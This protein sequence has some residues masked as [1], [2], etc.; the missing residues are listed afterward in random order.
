M[1]IR[2]TKKTRR[3]LLLYLAVLVALYIVVFQMPK[4][5]D[6]F[7]TTQV[8]ENGTLEVSCSAEGYIIKDEAVC[9]ASKTGV[10]HYNMEDGTVVKK[11]TK[12]ESIDDTATDKEKEH[13]VKG[14][15][16]DYLDKLQ[17]YDM[18]QATSVAPI[19]GVFSLS[20]DGNEKYLCSAN[21][22]KIKKE[23]VEEL[24]FK[25]IDLNREKVNEGEP[26]YKISNDDAWYIISWVEKADARKYEE[27]EKV[28]ITI[29]DTAL[30]AKVRTIKRDGE[31][32][33]MVFYL[34][35]YYE[36]FCS[37]RKV[38]MTVV[39]SN[40]M[41]LIV[42]NECIIEK[43]GQKGVYVKTKDGDTY[44]RPIKVKI[45]DGK[46][47]VIYESI[48]VNEKYEQVETV[49]V[50]QEVLRDPQEALEKDLADD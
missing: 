38:D 27:G 31:F 13:K 45:T 6:K 11:G 19:S 2:I 44:F 48:Y 33:R 4:V 29:G 17:G 49:R 30:D 39:Q 32:V 36:D 23:K 47:S 43:N 14:K 10:I 25:E 35:C 20:M 37:A 3:I 42:D 26:I 9:V 40:T 5:S 34:N 16:Q 21:L 50:Y 15:Y 8:L 28:R 22:D 7:E 41:G 12:I 24:D 18:L 46:Q 1:R